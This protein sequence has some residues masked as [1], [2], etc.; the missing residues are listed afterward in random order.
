MK[1][2]IHIQKE[3]REFIMRAFGIS[4]KSV[5]NAIRFDD[6]R[7][8]TDLAKKIR[9]LAM[10]RGGIVMVEVPEIETLH[11]ADGYMRQ[12]LPNNTLLEFDKEDGG[13]DVFHE[14][15][16]VRRYENVVVSDIKN[17]QG[18][19]LALG[20]PNPGCARPSKQVSLPSLARDLR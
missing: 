8:G 10:D 9:K 1:K 3:D 20:K 4:E 17:I 15:E 18:W 16:K 5:F 12:Y 7:G 13:C 19:A 11:D 2:Y 14:G 6:R